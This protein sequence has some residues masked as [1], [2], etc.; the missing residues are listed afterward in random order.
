MTVEITQEAIEFHP[1]SYCD[2]RGRVFWW[3]GE[4]YR[5][6]R[7][8]YAAFYQRLLAEGIVEQ[9]VAQKFL[10][11]TE[12]SDLKLPGYALVV[13]H[14]CLPFVSYAHE[15]CPEM[16][17][18]AALLNADLSLELAHFGLRLTDAATWNILFDGCRPV[19][20]DFC[21]LESID[22]LWDREWRSYRDDFYSYFI[23]PLRLMSQ[24]YGKLARWLLANGE[25]ESV[26][27]EFAALMGYR[28]PQRK[29]GKA[30]QVLRSLVEKTMPQAVRRGINAI[31]LPFSCPPG[32][33][34][35]R[36]LRRDL[37]SISLSALPLERATSDRGSDL[38]FV[39]SHQWTQKQQ[40][41]YQVLRDRCPATLLDVGSG[42]GWYSQLAAYLGIQVVAIDADEKSISHCYREAAQKKLPILPLI[43]DIQYPSPGQGTSYQVIAP[44]LDRLQCE[45][46]I[47]LAIVH[48]LVFEHRLT[49]EQIGETLATL[50]KKWLLVEFIPASDPE[51]YESRLDRYSWYTLDNLI[52]VLKKWFSP[53]TLL[54]SYPDSRILLLCEQ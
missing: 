31:K 28:Y 8:E 40:S 17:R 30:S 42:R 50:S 46:V 43:V 21:S 4:L 49:F 22:Y 10:I 47:A 12:L 23:H 27:R 41:V 37:E 33:E 52:T 5:G 15:W 19:M 14:R 7:Q 6:I 16:L 54:P 53:I 39:P 20:V 35:V 34:I 25:H 18:E 48:L 2:S 29:G 13:K 38:P 9:L 24:G 3:H 1:T 45:M 11:D 36:Q 26:H 32:I 51:I 44:A